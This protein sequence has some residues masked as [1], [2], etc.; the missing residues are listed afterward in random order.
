MSISDFLQKTIYFTIVSTL[1]LC[2]SCIRPSEKTPPKGYQRCPLCSGTGKKENKFLFFNFYS[3]CNFCGSLGYIKNNPFS[4]SITPDDDINNNGYNDA[5]PVDMQD[6]EPGYVPSD[7]IYETRQVWVDCYQCHG[8]GRC[9]ACNGDGWDI[10]TYSDGSFNTTYKC[11]VC[12]GNGTCQVC[13]GNRGHYEMQS[14]RV[15]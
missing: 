5:A 4:P 10:S 6:E 13:A 3:D 7:P 9:S 2:S 8:S 1:L 14:V 12:Y 15:Y 11:P